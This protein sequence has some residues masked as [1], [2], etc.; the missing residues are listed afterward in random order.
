MDKTVARSQGSIPIEIDNHSIPAWFLRLSDVSG[1]AGIIIEVLSNGF[2]PFSAG[3]QPMSAHRPRIFNPAAWTCG[4]AIPAIAETAA[5]RP[6]DLINSRR[7]VFGAITVFIGYIVVLLTG[8]LLT[9]GYDPCCGLVP[10]HSP[11]A[12]QSRVF[13]R[14]SFSSRLDLRPGYRVRAVHRLWRLSLQ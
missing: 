9:V 5:S 12:S 8:A 13:Q 11:T 14:P 6:V 3:A 4:I 10:T 2:S 1:L 7:V